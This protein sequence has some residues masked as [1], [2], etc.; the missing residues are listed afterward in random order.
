MASGNFATIAD[1]PAD[2]TTYDELEALKRAEEKQRKKMAEVATNEEEKN[3]DYKG[4]FEYA[5]FICGKVVIPKADE[6]S[7]QTHKKWCPRCIEKEKFRRQTEE[8]AVD[9]VQTLR[10]AII[11]Y[12]SLKKVLTEYIVNGVVNEKE[13]DVLEG[14]ALQFVKKQKQEAEDT[15]H[16]MMEDKQTGPKTREALNRVFDEYKGMTPKQIRKNYARYSL[17]QLF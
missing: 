11:V 14:Y 8:E 12:E 16:R 10:G 4:M 6:G 1:E 15:I 9:A 3:K 7:I 17:E 2:W 5:N 13:K